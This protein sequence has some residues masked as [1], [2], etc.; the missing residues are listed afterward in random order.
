VNFDDDDIAD[1]ALGAQVLSSGGG[2]PTDSAATIA[3]HAVSRQPVELVQLAELPADGLVVSVGVIGA[4]DLI[5]ERLPGPEFTLAVRAIE[6]HLGRR[7]VAVLAL[8]IGGSNGLLALSAAANL[9]MPIV[10]ADAIG[11]AFP[12]I[13]Q[14]SLTAAGIHCAPAAFANATGEIVLIDQADNFRMERIA[15]AALPALGAWAAM[16][17]YPASARELA[18]AIVVGSVSRAISLG[19]A[20]RD[21]QRDVA[22]R[23]DFPRVCGG[24]L[25]FD[26]IVTEVLRYSQDAPA[27]IVTLT[28]ARSS[29]EVMR[30]DIGSEFLYVAGDGLPLAVVPDIIVV[31]QSSSWEVVRPENVR[32]QQS[33][34]VL[35]I[36]APSPWDRAEHRELVGPLS[37]GLLEVIR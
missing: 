34:T 13:H 35:R 36:P 14:T 37:L 17:A 30:I 21:A 29:A 19:R 4:S 27:G 33:L 11:R 16:A 25:L 24:E 1:M 2:G 18:G 9:G 31:L 32:V 23:Q 26:G 6:R 28:H 12:G 8:A 7:A 15:R 10:D 22:L 20:L 5:E 3:R